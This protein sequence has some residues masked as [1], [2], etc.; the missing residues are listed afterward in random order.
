MTKIMCNTFAFPFIVKGPSEPHCNDPLANVSNRHISSQREAAT[1]L[2]SLSR[3]T[4]IVTMTYQM[5]PVLGTCA[6]GFYAEHSGKPTWR[7]DQPATSGVVGLDRT[8]IL[9]LLKLPHF[10]RGQYATACIKELLAVMHGGDIWLDIPFPITIEFI[11]QKTG[12]PSWGMDPT[13]IL[14]HKSKEKA[15]S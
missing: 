3:S 4:S 14:D 5:K 6:K 13:L 12:L 7:N 10:G 8:S 2:A 1:I 9:G 15:L 11:A